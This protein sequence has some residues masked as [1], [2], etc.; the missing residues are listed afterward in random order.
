MR[1]ADSSYD[2]IVLGSGAAGLAAALSAL[3]RGARVAVFEKGNVVGGSTAL[4][5]GVT[6]LPNHPH[7]R[8]H[9]YSDS[10]D[11]ALKYLESLS[12]G[13]IDA[14]LAAAFVDTAAEL[15]EWIEKSTPLQ[16]QLFTGFPDYHPE[17]PGGKPEGGRSV[18]PGLVDFSPLGEWA[19][20]IVVPNRN[21]YLGVQESTFAGGGQVSDEE[22]EDR[23]SRNIRGGGP[24]LIAALLQGVLERGGH[25]Q[26]GARARHLIRMDGRVVGVR[27]E[28]DRGDFAIDARRGVIIAT[29]G[30]EWDKG[31][32]RDFLRGPMDR[33]ASI[34]TNTG[35]GLRMAMETGAALGNM[36]E[37]W[38]VPT[39]DVPGEDNYGERRVYHVQRERIL[40]RSILVNRRGRRF[41]NEAT[42]YNALGAALHHFDPTRF[43][44]ANLPCWLIFDQEHVR[45]YGFAKSPPGETPPWATS[46][47]TLGS[48]AR[49]LGISPDGLLATVE[50][51]NAMV[52]EGRDADFGR[53]ESAYSLWLG[54]R[55]LT[56]PARTLGPV[57]DAPYYAVEVH[58][59]SLGTKGG[60]KTT[61]D[62][63]VIDAFGD[64][65]PGLYAAGN[66]MAGVTGMVYGGGGGTLGPALVF[67]FRAGRH[68]ARASMA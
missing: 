16:F 33:P 18:E 29:G 17:N 34:P 43:V 36:R 7:M 54:D 48:L 14:E 41:A 60:P 37:A 1:R 32:V 27:F 20:R 23:R 5:G 51:W 26:A 38:W 65:I 64:T 45:R 2:V 30:F 24:A 15:V 12:H 25:V 56:G 31:L 68:A 28:S 4:S 49:Q 6:W 44:Y 13:L 53:G 52:A 59:G 46:A 66:A 50:R 61:A 21:P 42:N 47:P 19:E 22:L 62:G 67:G 58:S 11:E 8:E 40:P 3:D 55:L 10:R 63:Q 39:V 9:G 35:D 57:T